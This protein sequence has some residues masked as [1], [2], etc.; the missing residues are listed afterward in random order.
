M[1]EEIMLEL[2]SPGIVS[3]IPIVALCHHV[4]FFRKSPAECEVQPGTG[5]DG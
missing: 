5:Y 3:I 4:G 1:I 2:G